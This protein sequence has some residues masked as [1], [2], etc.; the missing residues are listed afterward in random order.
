MAELG[1]DLNAAAGQAI[2]TAGHTAGDALNAY[3]IVQQTQAARQKLE[4]DKDQHEMNKAQWLTG[5]ISQLS[6]MPEGHAKK[7]AIDT[8][9]PQLKQVYPNANPDFAELFK[10]DPTYAQ[11]M[12]A[13]IAAIAPDI[14]DP[15][16][17]KDLG[18]FMNSATGPQMDFLHNV[19]QEKATVLAGQ[20]KAQSMEGR[21]DVMKGNQAIGAGKSFDTD[22]IIKMSQTNVNSL[23]RSQNILE[24]PKLPVTAKDLNL[25]YN[26][27]INAVAAGGAATEG[28]ISREL[29]ETFET[30]FNNLRMKAGDL[31][32]LRK[33]DSGRHLIDQ[34]RGRINGVNDD[35][36]HA[37]SDRASD[38]Y[39]TY[40]TAN[41]ETEAVARRKLR[42][43]APDV[44]SSLFG[45]GGNA[46]AAPAQA[47]AP[48]K[49]AAVPDYL[50]MPAGLSKEDFLKHM[51]GDQ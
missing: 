43:Y 46:Q 11:G 16:K 38:L 17:A 1:E 2:Q 39:S 34:L 50:S 29:P 36:H 18:D 24:N 8:M 35:I 44:H 42:Q 3:Q 37:I 25:A 5:Q 10:K 6:A 31:A 30:E 33:S 13:H 47:P 49:T 4:E 9:A 28:K 22:P 45:G 14:V 21:V 51:A 48:K 27:Y 12:A 23:K 41:P 7:M 15:K 26:D 20:L 19:L 32:D 40:S